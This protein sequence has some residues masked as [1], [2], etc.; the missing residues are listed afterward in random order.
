LTGLSTLDAESGA[1][2]IVAAAV[3]VLIAL[4]AGGVAASVIAAELSA[5]LRVE[6]ARLG[7]PEAAALDTLTDG[8]AEPV[9]GAVFR[10]LA[11][12]ATLTGQATVVPALAGPVAEA[13]LTVGVFAAFLIR[14]AGGAHW[15]NR[16]CPETGGDQPSDDG[17]Q[18]RPA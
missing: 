18:R 12:T 11:A 6:S 1:A 3:I 10:G 14:I 15:P 4:G 13:A 2:A 16:A 9:V 5:T 8:A 17:A 7:V